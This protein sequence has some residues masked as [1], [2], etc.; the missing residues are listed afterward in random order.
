M[1]NFPTF[2]PY[3]TTVRRPFLLSSLKNRINLR[4]ENSY[5]FQQY[6]PRFCR[7]EKIDPRKFSPR[8]REIYNSNFENINMNAQD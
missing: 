4:K 6:R 3:S 1:N 7:G 2:S 8:R 5:F